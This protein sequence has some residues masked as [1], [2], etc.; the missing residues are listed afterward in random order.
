MYALQVNKINDG[1]WTVAVPCKKN[2]EAEGDSHEIA[3]RRAEPC[4]HWCRDYL[5]ESSLS[6]ENHYTYVDGF[7][8]RCN[9]P[10]DGMRG[11]YRHTLKLWW[12]QMSQYCEAECGRWDCLLVLC[13]HPTPCIMNV[14]QKLV[15]P[16]ISSSGQKTLSVVL[17]TFWKYD[18]AYPAP[19]IFCRIHTLC[20]Q[21]P[22]YSTF[23]VCYTEGWSEF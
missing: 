16:V 6:S 21:W 15:R 23:C 9:N 2:W 11:E 5:T 20:S 12:G 7:I 4:K 17:K 14:E 3:A 19:S 13:F 8:T 18:S 22:Q 10:N 1:E